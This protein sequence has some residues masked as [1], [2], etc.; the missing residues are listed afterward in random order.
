MRLN[1]LR[2]LCIAHRGTRLEKNVMDDCRYC[3]YFSEI[4]R[5]WKTP[6]LNALGAAN[7]WHTQIRGSMSPRFAYL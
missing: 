5:Y 2:K 3:T 4:Q 6:C 7:R 1:I